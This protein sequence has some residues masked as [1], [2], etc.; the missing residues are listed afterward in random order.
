MIIR[1]LTNHVGL[2]VSHSPFTTIIVTYKCGF[3]TS[4]QD[5]N[6][7]NSWV[8]QQGSLKYYRRLNVKSS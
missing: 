3:F 4:K 5:E 7:F 6:D 2:F 8:K 1:Y